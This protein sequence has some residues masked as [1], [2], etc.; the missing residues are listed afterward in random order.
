MNSS[1][2]LQNLEGGF[3]VANNWKYGSDVGESEGFSFWGKI[4]AIGIIFNRI[5]V[6]QF[7]LSVL[8]TILVLIGIVKVSASDSFKK[9]FKKL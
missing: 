2:Y 6:I 4:D 5:M 8:F 9:T 7:L 1:E 3:S